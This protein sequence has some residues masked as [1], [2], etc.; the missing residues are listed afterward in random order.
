M[1]DRIHAFWVINLPKRQ[2]VA[3]GHFRSFDHFYLNVI[4]KQKKYVEI[5]RRQYLM[6]HGQVNIENYSKNC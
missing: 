3:N 5:I 4:S 2:V 6:P 1:R